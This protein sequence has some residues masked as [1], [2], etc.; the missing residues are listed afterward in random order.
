MRSP[1]PRSLLL[2]AVP[3]LIAALSLV[4]G[5]LG[6]SS[7]ANGSESAH[8][9]ADEL[10]ISVGTHNTLRGRARFM[11]IGEVIGW[12]EVMGDRS[13]R[14]MRQ[15]LPDYRHYVPS[16]S[17]G[18]VPISFRSGTWQLV[19]AGSVPAHDGVH[20]ITPDRFINWVVLEH[21]SGHTITFVNTHFINGAF[22]PWKSRYQ[23]R[24]RLWHRHLDTLVA[25]LREL[26]TGRDLTFVVGDFNY[27]RTLRLPGVVRTKARSRTVDQIYVPGAGTGAFSTAAAAKESPPV[28]RRRGHF[29]SDHAAWRVVYPLP[30]TTDNS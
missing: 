9:H 14:K 10:Q 12:Q 28:A 29:G 21:D 15:Q 17:A 19:D 6:P 1:G 26:N 30:S 3:P 24:K 20:G 2:H 25:T 23:L 22:K 18:A 7:A 8:V 4:C 13:R 11:P 27:K 5:L 16:S